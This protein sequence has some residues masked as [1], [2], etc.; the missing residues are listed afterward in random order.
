MKWL[1]EE[2]LNGLKLS[3]GIKKK[4]VSKKSKF[5]LIDIV[6]TLSHGVVMSLDKKIMVSEKD[7][8]IYHEMIAHVPLFMQGVPKR[9]LIIGGGDGGTVR[10]CLKHLYVENIDLCEI[11]NEVIELSKKYMP[12]TAKEL[13]NKKVNIFVQ[14]GFAF[15]KE[16]SRQNSYDLIIVDSSDPVGIAA[17]L[18]KDSFFSLVKNALRPKGIVC[19]Q[20]ESPFFYSKAITTAHKNLKRLF[21]SVQHF[22][23][24]VTTYPSGY[25]SFVIASDQEMHFKKRKYEKVSKSMYLKYYNSEIHKSAFALPNFFKELIK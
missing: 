13:K 8:F 2:Q 24:P 9:I 6:Q 25:W 22:T 11:D 23:A 19:A 16:K 20:C 12:F 15:L 3:F 4:L 14:D 5:Q 1:T 7:E 21:K 17:N 18:F 10:E